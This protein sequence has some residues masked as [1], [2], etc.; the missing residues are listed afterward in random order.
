MSK[1]RKTISVPVTVK[2]SSWGKAR[3]VRVISK[4]MSDPRAKGGVVEIPIY[5]DV[6][7]PTNESIIPKSCQP[8]TPEHA[9]TAVKVTK[10]VANMLRHHIPDFVERCRS[11]QAEKAWQHIFSDEPKTWERLCREILHIEPRFIEKLEHAT[12]FLAQAEEPTP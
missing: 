1:S 4:T 5:R 8:G 9:Q 12:G 10:N 7:K 11:L 3:T 2:P 6:G